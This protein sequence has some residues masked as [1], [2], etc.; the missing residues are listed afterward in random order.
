MRN[1]RQDFKFKGGVRIFSTDLVLVLSPTFCGRIVAE[2]WQQKHKIF[3]G[4]K[5]TTLGHFKLSKTDLK[6][7]KLVICF[8]KCHE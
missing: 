7:H 3:A 5:T 1:I 2:T 4:N 8:S 6:L